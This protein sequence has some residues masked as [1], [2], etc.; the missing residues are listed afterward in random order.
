MKHDCIL[1]E[2]AVKIV[3]N[4]DVSA[5]SK[6]AAAALNNEAA[7]ISVINFDYLYYE[8]KT[9]NSEQFFFLSCNM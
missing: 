4:S 5:F 1:V 3:K 7:N 6:K 9:R 8:L 2:N